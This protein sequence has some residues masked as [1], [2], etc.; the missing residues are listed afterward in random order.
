MV[1]WAAVFLVTT[2]IMDWIQS[3]SPS[4]K[5]IFD[6]FFSLIATRLVNYWLKI[7]MK[8]ILSNFK[9][10]VKA[11]QESSIMTSCVTLLEGLSALSNPFATLHMWRMPVWMWQIELF[12]KKIKFS[13][14][15]CYK[16]GKMSENWSADN[17]VANEKIR[18]DIS[19]L[20]D[21]KTKQQSFK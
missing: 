2:S 13:Q 1:F 18:L 21:M 15:C 11:E 9:A 16:V 19:G 5:I 14:L 17:N 20:N 3:S 4:I 12:P 8:K 7:K 10:F 6:G